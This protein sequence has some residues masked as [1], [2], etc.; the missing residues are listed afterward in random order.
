MQ[1]VFDLGGMGGGGR[2]FVKATDEMWVEEEEE[3]NCIKILLNYVHAHTPFAT[4]TDHHPCRSQGPALKWGSRPP[5]GLGSVL[6]NMQLGS[7]WSSC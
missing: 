5:G 3:K 2:N 6:G 4:W 1:E 7:F